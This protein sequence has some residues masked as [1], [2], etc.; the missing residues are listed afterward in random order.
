MFPVYIDELICRL[1]KS[2]IGCFIGKEY[3]GC[4]SY[5]D[6]FGLL[7]PSVKGLQRMV[8]LSSE[9]GLE[10]S[11]TYNAKKTKCVKFELK[12]VMPET[13]HIRLEF[14]V[15]DWTKVLEWTTCRKLYQE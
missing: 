13:Y 7:C 10:F 14:K 8:D 2:G 4:L 5:A 1:Q 12:P 3:Y 15:L 9:F 11:V 6:D